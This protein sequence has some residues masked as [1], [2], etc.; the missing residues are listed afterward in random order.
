MRRDSP[1]ALGSVEA[2]R[3]DTGRMRRVLRGIGELFG[4]ALAY[5]GYRHRWVIL[6][7]TALALPL[8]YYLAVYI[9]P[10]AAGE[11]DF[12][13]NYSSFFQTSAQVIA[14]LLVVIAVETRFA[15]KETRLAIREARVVA[16]LWMVVAEIAALTALSPTLP[17]GLDRPSFRLVVGGGAA[18]LIAIVLTAARPGPG[19]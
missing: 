2:E 15:T 18:G 13:T 10:E 16:V 3:R 1:D 7:P 12:Y 11:A 5:M 4:V 8:G 14:A 17:L 6:V 9:I 19:E